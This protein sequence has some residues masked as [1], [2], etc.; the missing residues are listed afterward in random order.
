MV[1]SE[2]GESFAII[3]RRSTRRR[4]IQAIKAMMVMPRTTAT[5]TPIAMFFETALLGLPAPV[6][7]GFG[8]LVEEGFPP[9][10][11]KSP[12]SG[13]KTQVSASPLATSW[14]LDWMEESFTLCRSMINGAG[15]GTE[16][17]VVQLGPRAPINDVFPKR[18][19]F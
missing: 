12:P 17:V 3:A 9:N 4:T 2:E 18:T 5:A 19:L 13:G 15:F 1:E 14:K 7:W 8:G 11:Q 6:D 16:S 10:G